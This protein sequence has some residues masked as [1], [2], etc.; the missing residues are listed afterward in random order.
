MAGLNSNLADRVSQVALTFDDKTGAYNQHCTNI[1][2][3]GKL[4]TAQQ[5][6][7]VVALDLSGSTQARPPSGVQPACASGGL[8]RD[9]ELPP[10]WLARRLSSPPGSSDRPAR[11]RFRSAAYAVP[12]V[13]VCMQWALVL[14]CFRAAWVSLKIPP[15]LRH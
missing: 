3:T 14:R 15:A 10:R 5:H 13:C 11:S 2:H 1:E 4:E 9:P 7:K 12:R 6:Q 8:A